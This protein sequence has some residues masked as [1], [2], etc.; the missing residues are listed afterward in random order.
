[1][2]AEAFFLGV[3]KSPDCVVKG[4]TETVISGL[5]LYQTTKF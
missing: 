3:V 4:L 2:F 1:M 5:T